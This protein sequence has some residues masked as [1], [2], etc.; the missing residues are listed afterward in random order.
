MEE[1][2]NS[3]LELQ[4]LIGQKRFKIFLTNNFK[5]EGKILAEDKNFVKILEINGAIRIVSKH[6]I[7]TIEVL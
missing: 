4:E 7:T 2:M 3:E 1:K 5:Y 6:Q